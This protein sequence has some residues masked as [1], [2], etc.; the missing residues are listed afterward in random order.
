MEITYSLS[1]ILAH[2]DNMKKLYLISQSENNGHDTFDSAVVC[3]ENE[4]EALHI[5]P[6]GRH[7][8][9]AD[10][11][12]TVTWAKTEKDVTVTKIGITDNDALNGTVICASFN[13]F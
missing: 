1:N 9:P 7:K 8:F 12:W 13:T 11:Y 5:H 2:E 3:A 6:D 10:A 4:E